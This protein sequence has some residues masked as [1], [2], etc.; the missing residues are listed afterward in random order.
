VLRA[1]EEEL[2]AHE[3]LLD[4]IDKQAKDKGGSVWRRL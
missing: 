1:T 2:R 4:G 3:K